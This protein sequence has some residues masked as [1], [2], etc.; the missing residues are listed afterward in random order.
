[1]FGIYW[2][3][4]FTN[5]SVLVLLF[6]KLSNFLKKY[7]F[8]QQIFLGLE[9]FQFEHQFTPCNTTGPVGPNQIECDNYYGRGVVKIN[10]ELFGYQVWTVPQTGSYS[11]TV[12]GAQGGSINQF[13]GEAKGKFGGKGV[14]I[15]ARFDLIQGEEL[16]IA[17]GQEGGSHKR[18]NGYIAA[19]GGGGT[20]IT[21]R[22]ELNSLTKEDILLIGGGGG[23]SCNG[24][25]GYKCGPAGDGIATEDIADNGA[26]KGGRDGYG[27]EGK[28]YSCGG[29]G[30]IGNGKGNKYIEEVSKSMTNG[31]TGG[32]SSSSLGV[33]GGFGGGGFGFAGAGY[34]G[35]GGGY[36]CCELIYFI[37]KNIF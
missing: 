12:G 8:I 9:C 7:I 10:D 18:N 35:G 31:L 37:Y 16:F 22:K 29:S 3:I 14:I 5:A 13:G 4:F 34:G 1:M 11:I 20:F 30:F 6:L 26:A 17:V 15:S 24:S 32:I 36:R 33:S 28:T 25:G 23:G 27:G 19:G 2:K 21:K